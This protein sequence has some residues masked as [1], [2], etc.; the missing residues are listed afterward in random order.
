M[1][2]PLPELRTERLVLRSFTER[3]VDAVLA[4]AGDP[5]VSRYIGFLPVPYARSDAERFLAQILLEDTAKHARYAIELDG[6]VIGCSNLDIV[7]DHERAELGYLLRHDAWGRGFATEAASA[8][9]D[10]GFRHYGLSLV[11]AHADPRN[12]AS[13]RVLAKLGFTHEGTLRRRWRLRGESIDVVSY[14]QTREE[15]DAAGT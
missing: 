5:E 2:D 1:S 8:V 13:L 9:R 4:Y 3:D 12:P 15:W 11:H 14:S 6:D 10:H 7:P